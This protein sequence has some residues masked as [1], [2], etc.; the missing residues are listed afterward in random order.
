MQIVKGIITLSAELS[1]IT[2]H[3]FTPGC[4]ESNDLPSTWLLELPRCG[5]GWAKCLGLRAAAAHSLKATD[6]E[7]DHVDEVNPT[8]VVTMVTG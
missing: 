2:V 4:A 6:R 8:E 3:R 1:C 7:E 5:G